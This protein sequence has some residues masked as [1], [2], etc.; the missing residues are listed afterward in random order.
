LLLNGTAGLGFFPLAA[1]QRGANLAEQ[2][3][4]TTYGET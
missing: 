2:A 4:L 3:L 1:M